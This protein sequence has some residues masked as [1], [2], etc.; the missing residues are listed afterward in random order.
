M[1]VDFR[2][3]V[4]VGFELSYEDYAAEV[5]WRISHEPDKGRKWAKEIQDYLIILDGYTEESNYIFSDNYVTTDQ[6]YGQSILSFFNKSAIS[7]ERNKEMIAAFNRLFPRV[8]K[9]SHQLDI[10]YALKVD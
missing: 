9:E 1:G 8:D 10:L 3:V 4:A 6:S 2:A 5:S 7:Y